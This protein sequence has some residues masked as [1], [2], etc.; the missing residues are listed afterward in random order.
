MQDILIVI[1]ARYSSSRFPGKPLA[2]I[3]GIEMIKR[4]ADIARN[5][6]DNNHDCNYVVATDDQRIV[7]F[8]QQHSIPVKTS[9]SS[10]QSGT[11]RCWD[12]V[13]NSNEKPKFIINLQGD[14]PLC[15]P[16][17]IQALIDNWRT[18]SADIFTPYIQLS[19]DEFAQF[20]EN[21]QTTPFSGTSVLVDKKGF[22]LAFSKNVLPAIRHLDEAKKQMEKSPVKRHIGLYGYTFSALRDYFTLSESL[23]EKS[24]I[25]GLE[26]M[27]F[28]ENGLKVKMVEVDYQGRKTTS[29][30]DS[31]EDVLRVEQIIAEFG[32]LIL[33]R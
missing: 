20:I 4:V 33:N 21:K 28:L 16:H 29:G 8:C 25:E 31:P 15:P 18:E 13:A 19:W 1:P 27:R 7:G 6:C 17:V 22:A 5:I 12:I 2:K 23:C 30:V 24:Y 14:N 3:A 10:C 9:C 32:E 26:Q 11:E